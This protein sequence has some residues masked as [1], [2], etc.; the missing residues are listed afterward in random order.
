M[1]L[2]HEIKIIET[3]LERLLRAG[4]KNKADV[5]LYMRIIKD[6][7]NT[8]KLESYRKML[9][10][11]LDKVLIMMTTDFTIFSRV[12]AL[13][14]KKIK[15]TEE[16]MTKVDTIKQLVA[17]KVTIRS[18]FKLKPKPSSKNWGVSRASKPVKTLMGKYLKKAG[19]RL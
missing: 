15:I 8:S 12:E 5:E 3:R 18:K 17:E 10:K 13:L 4:C 11:L 16:N 1:I 14:Q 9:M 19:Y 7:K 6:S 2:E